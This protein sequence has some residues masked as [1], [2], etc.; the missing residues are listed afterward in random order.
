MRRNA[1]RHHGVYRKPGTS[2]GLQ[3]RRGHGLGPPA[4]GAGDVGEVQLDPKLVLA[5]LIVGG[6]IGFVIAGREAPEEDKTVTTRGVWPQYPCPPNSTSLSCDAALMEIMQLAYGAGQAEVVD[7]AA[8][9]LSNHA[10]LPNHI[11]DQNQA[12]R[13]NDVWAALTAARSADW[14]G[15]GKELDHEDN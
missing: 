4:L 14:G 10:Q 6:V 12:A 7:K 9:C 13:S 8:Q 15:C 2:G 5:A 11:G 3:D 1:A